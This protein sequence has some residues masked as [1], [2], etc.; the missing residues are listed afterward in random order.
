M[1][2]IETKA[3]P[4]R[5]RGEPAVGEVGNDRRFVGKQME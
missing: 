5:V 2:E 1:K 4:E 3:V